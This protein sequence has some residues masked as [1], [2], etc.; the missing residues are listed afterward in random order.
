MRG[1][2]PVIAIGVAA[3]AF[4]LATVAGFE[5]FGSDF[6]SVFYVLP[7]A[8]VAAVLAAVGAGVLTG[9]DLQPP[10]H[11]VLAGVAAFGY[12]VF[13]QL[14][15]RYAVASTRRVLQ[16]DVIV[17]VAALAALLATAGVWYREADSR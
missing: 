13:I 15:T 7:I 12:A 17:V 9:R 1:R 14:A 10:V 6:P 2:R 3:T 11:G 4:I 5:V 8:L 16:V